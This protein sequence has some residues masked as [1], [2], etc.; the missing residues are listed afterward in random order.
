MNRLIEALLQFSRLA[1]AELK[2]DRVDLSRMAE[3]VAWELKA[4]GPDRPVTFRLAEGIRVDGDAN[5]LRVV[6]TNLLGNAWKYT[7]TQ[8]E[9]IIEFAVTELDGRPFF[10]IRDNGNGFDMANADKLFVPFQR[11]PGAEE[12]RGFGIGL[13]TVERIIRR[14]G[15]QV[16]AEGAIG[17]GSTFYFTLQS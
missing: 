16:W 8:K 1:H 2:R 5:L 17:K 14:H 11:L 15:G 4:T 7:A 12:C 6:L 9:A 13:A 10:L 3:E